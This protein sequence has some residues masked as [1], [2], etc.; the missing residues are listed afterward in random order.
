MLAGSLAMAADPDRLAAAREAVKKVAAEEQAAHT[1][2]NAREMARSATREIAVAARSTADRALQAVLAVQ[3][4]LKQ[5]QAA[6]RAAR[7][8]VAQATGPDQQR[9]REQAAR[10]DADAAAAERKLAD[11]LT[12][13]RSAVERM[14][15]DQRV[16]NQAAE[17][18]RVIERT[19]GQKMQSTRAAERVV[20][21]L[22]AETARQAAEKTPADKAA[23]EKATAAE[24]AVREADVVL[25]WEAQAWLGVQRSTLQQMSAGNASAA[26]LATK[27]VAVEPDA[28]RQKALQEFAARMTARKD[29]EDRAAAEKLAEARACDRQM[30]LLRA[31]AAGG[32]RPLTPESWDYAKARHLLVRAGFGGTPQEVARLHALGLYRAVDCLVDFHRQPIAKAPFEAAPPPRPDPLEARLRNDFIRS[33]VSSARGGAEGG[34]LH[35]LRLWWIKRLVESPRPL[36]EKLTLFWHGHFAT[37]YSVVRNSYACY[38][39][40]QMFREHAAGNFGGLLYGIVHDPVMIRY[41][42]NNTNVKGHANENL[43]REIMELF[44]MGADQGYTEK[45]IREAARALTGYTYDHATGQFRFDARQHDDGPKTVFGKTGNFTGDDVVKLILEQPATSRFIAGKLFR[46]FAHA[47][48]SPDVAERLAFVLRSNNYEL[49]PLLKNLFLSEEFY[50]ERTMA[51]QIKSPVQLVVG[52]LRDLGVK[53]VSDA[54]ALDRTLQGMGQELF[55]PPDVK[56]WREGR[57]WINSNRIFLRYNAVAELLRTVRQPRNRSGVDVV[58][59]LEGAGCCTAADVVDFLAKACLSR[60]LSPDK[61]AELIHYLGE[62]PP[63]AQWTSQKD[64][65]NDRFRGVLILLTSM[66]EYQLT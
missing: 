4:T 34:Q 6:A 18:L 50:S 10:A 40:N 33:Q 65:L 1:E 24:R 25:T 37:Q 59:L 56:G 57:S 49:A 19:L 36:Q 64:Q 21:A 27:L 46:F 48:P 39:Q 7:E 54:Q 5:K 3:E 63:P 60:P 15:N 13:L 14:L 62:L 53:E 66:P 26:E 61:R 55:E 12:T 35:R 32:L 45:D 51:T 44:A 52:L 20:L 28:N 42:D 23:A 31:A 38:V 29:A 22:E 43:A 41:L 47:D 17:D 8:A 30:D 2:W 11:R 16:A 9:A 58:A